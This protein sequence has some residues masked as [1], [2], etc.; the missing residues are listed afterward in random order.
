[1]KEAR[2]ESQET[3]MA[4]PGC[5]GQTG[6]QEENGRQREQGQVLW[7]EHRD[8]AGLCRYGIRKGNAQLELDSGKN[9]EQE[10][11]LQ[12]HKP[13]KESPR[14]CTFASEYRAA[15]WILHWVLLVSPSAPP[16]PMCSSLASGAQDPCASGNAAVV[17]VRGPGGSRDWESAGV[18]TRGS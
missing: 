16:S 13:E 15:M 10:R 5:G 1:M 17:G 4:E 8:A 12:I 18:L 14:Q 3:S 9:E 6:Q 11:L 2:K 7:G